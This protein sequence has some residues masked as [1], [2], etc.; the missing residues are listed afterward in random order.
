MKED[1]ICLLSH[2]ASLLK[3]FLQHCDWEITS[4]VTFTVL[5]ISLVDIKGYF[6]WQKPSHVTFSQSFFLNLIVKFSVS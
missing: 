3:I 2:V 6:D 5:N 4:Y 1:E